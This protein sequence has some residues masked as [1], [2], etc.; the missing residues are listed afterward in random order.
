MANLIVQM[1]VM[2]E[3]VLQLGRTTI[4]TVT[5][6]SLW[7]GKPHGLFVTNMKLK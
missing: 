5:D 3:D 7:M 1:E 4:G 2:K 6:V